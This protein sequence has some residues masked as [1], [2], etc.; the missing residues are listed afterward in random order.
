M[1]Y[2]HGITIKEYREKLGF[3]NPILQRYGRGQEEISG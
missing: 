2:H 3:S 1:S